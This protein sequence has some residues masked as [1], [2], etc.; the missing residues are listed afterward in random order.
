MELWLA[1]IA[2]EVVELPQLLDPH[3]G[4]VVDGIKPLVNFYLQQ[5]ILLFSL[6]DQELVFPQ[7]L[8]HGLGG[9]HMEASLQGSQDDVKVSVVRSEDGANIARLSEFLQSFQVGFPVHPATLNREQNQSYKLRDLSQGHLRKLL[10]GEVCQ[11]GKCDFL[12]EMFPDVG[13]LGPV[14][15]AESD[16]VSDQAALSEVEVDEGDHP[17]ALVRLGALLSGPAGDVFASAENNRIHGHHQC[18][19]QPV[20]DTVP[21]T[22]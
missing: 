5:N 15:A 8:H 10:K 18:Q 21:G 9:H 4:V 12:L 14:S 19:C 22:T 13:K 11:V 1:H 16:L 2:G 17:Q 3:P 7:G 20:L 6:L